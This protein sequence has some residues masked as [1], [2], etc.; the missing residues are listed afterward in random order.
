M[1]D[2]LLSTLQQ[3]IRA[4]LNDIADDLAGGAAKSFD[5]YMKLV[6]M[7]EGLA[8]AERHLLDLVDIQER[9]ET[10]EMGMIQ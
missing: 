6:G 9:A 8:R 10:G 7:I 3:E 5:Q 2:K 1:P 4:D